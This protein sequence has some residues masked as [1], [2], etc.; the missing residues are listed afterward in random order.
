M[1]VDDIVAHAVLPSFDRLA[2]WHESSRG[3]IQAAIGSDRAGLNKLSKDKARS[4]PRA[5][6]VS[7]K[8]A[9]REAKR[10][11]LTAPAALS[12]TVSQT[13]RNG[14]ST[15]ELTSSAEISLFT[16]DQPSSS[17]C[18]GTEGAPASPSSSI[19]KPH[20][21]TVPTTSSVLPWYPTS[22]KPSAF[23]A[24][25]PITASL[26]QHQH[27]YETLEAARQAGLWTYPSTQ[28]ERARCAVF[29]DLHEKGYWMGGGLKF[30]GDWLVYPGRSFLPSDG[31]KK[32]ARVAQWLIVFCF[33]LLWDC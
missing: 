9:E 27:E 28:E 14:D 1:L 11:A 25:S 31:G 21:V 5:D 3:D 33:F 29:R 10:A 20:S 6:V 15:D 18:S 4:A 26:L 2:K 23:A 22:A 32:C 19:V 12:I 30:G 17:I 8:R 13:S 16:P 7:A 24:A